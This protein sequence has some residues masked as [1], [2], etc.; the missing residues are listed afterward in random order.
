VRFLSWRSSHWCLSEWLT[1]S[2]MVSW[3]GSAMEPAV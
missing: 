2:A 3:T 1:R